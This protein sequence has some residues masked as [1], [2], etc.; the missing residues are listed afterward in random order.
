MMRR[1]KVGQKEGGQGEINEKT[2]KEELHLV[3]GGHN[4]GMQG[5]LVAP[6]KGHHLEE[7]ENLDLAKRRRQQ[8][9]QS[10]AQHQPE[11]RAVRRDFQVRFE[12]YL[13]RRHL[14]RR[15]EDNEDGLCVVVINHAVASQ[16]VLL[17]GLEV[18][19][20]AHEQLLWVAVSLIAI[21]LETIGLAHEFCELGASGGQQWKE[22]NTKRVRARVHTHRGDQPR[23]R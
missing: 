11:K 12:P 8:A 20:G 19:Q 14:C 5:A 6:G 4:V 13:G 1:G 18:P 17:D 10:V 2:G 7:E 3:A 9:V 16:G 15:D 22:A 23:S 21:T